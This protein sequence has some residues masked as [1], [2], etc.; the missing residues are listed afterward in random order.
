[1]AFLSFYK[2]N[3]CLLDIYYKGYE[4][5]MKINL[6][7]ATG[8]IGR[9]TLAIMRVY[10]EKFTLVACAG[11]NNI[12]AMRAIIREFSPRLV[13]VFR[14]DDARRLRGE[15]PFLQI[16]SGKAGLNEVACYA[17]GNI[18]VNAVMGS[19]GLE[20]TL[21]AIRAKKKIALA[22][23]ETLVTAGSLVMEEARKAGIEILPIDSEHSAIWQCLHN[24]KKEQVARI[25]LTASGGSFRDLNREQ[26]QAVTVQDALN[27]PVWSMGKKITIDSATLMNKGLEVIEAHWLFGLSYD[28]IDVVLHRESIVH[29]LVEFCDGSFLAQL[30]SPNMVVPI[31][32]ALTYP[33]RL[34]WQKEKPFSLAEAGALNFQEVDYD[35]FPCLKL[36]CEAG[37]KGGTMP[38]VLNAA[39]EIAVQAFLDGHITFLEIESTI[40]ESLSSHQVIL[41]PDL[42][43]IEQV[44]YET[45]YKVKEKI[46]M[47]R[48]Y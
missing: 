12:D 25:I 44:D 41:E 40:G 34:P 45:R 17:A 21:V 7:G 28:K 32:Y 36:A 19:I 48:G 47:K 20:P 38:T 24:E 39:N 11:G 13:S 15:F 14:E 18:V 9:Q 23:K 42:A 8:S 31:L 6:L 4:V 3:Y 35:R 27:H 2:L 10:K 30:G 29:S 5:I 43:T 16:R 46:E 37:K 33:E 1:M 22:N 26:L